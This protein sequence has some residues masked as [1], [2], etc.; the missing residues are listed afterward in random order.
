MAEE[1]KKPPSSLGLLLSGKFIDASGKKKVPVIG[2]LLKWMSSNDMDYGPLVAAIGF[3]LL[4]VSLIIFGVSLG[5]VLS[6]FFV[7]TPLWLPIV[8]FLLFYEKWM[9]VVGT[10]FSLSQGRTTLRLRLPQD[11]FKSPEA[12]E[13]VISQIHN[14]A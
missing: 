6:V 1:K 12:M 5:Q 9:E 8:L 2:S 7:L 4:A 10:S 3:L 11:V 13:F 14:T